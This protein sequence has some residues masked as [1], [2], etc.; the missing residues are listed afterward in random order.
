MKRISQP[1]EKSMTLLMKAY[2]AAGCISENSPALVT[3][4]GRNCWAV[5][6]SPWAGP[7]RLF[8]QACAISPCGLRLI[9]IQC[10]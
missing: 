9:Q 7:G 6:S 8:P 1:Y 2:N 4:S 3:H 10:R 5:G